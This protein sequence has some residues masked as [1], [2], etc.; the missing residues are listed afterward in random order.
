VGQAL[1]K[2]IDQAALR[3]VFAIFLVVMGIVILVR[4]APRV[5]AG[6]RTDDRG[7]AVEEPA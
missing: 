1:S 4:E 2:R 7:E 3:R 5:F 6:E